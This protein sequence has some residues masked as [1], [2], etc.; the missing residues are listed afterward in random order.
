MSCYSLLSLSQVLGQNRG[1]RMGGE[2][3]KSPPSSSSLLGPCQYSLRSPASFL[4]DLSLPAPFYLP[5]SSMPHLSSPLLIAWYCLSRAVSLPFLGL[6]GAGL[7]PL[8]LLLPLLWQGVGP[9]PTCCSLRQ[10][11]LLNLCWLPAALEP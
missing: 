2:R 10:S 11:A 8:L 3:V 1:L 5:V 7:P 6:V 4:L 9:L